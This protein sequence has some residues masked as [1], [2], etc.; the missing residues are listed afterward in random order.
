MTQRG[1]MPRLMPWH[2]GVVNGKDSEVLAA[3]LNVRLHELETL[4]EQMRGSMLYGPIAGA[5]VPFFFS[6]HLAAGI[7]TGI[8]DQHSTPFSFLPLAVSVW[9]ENAASQL[10]VQLRYD[11]G[12]PFDILA[13]DLQFTG[14]SFLNQRA[15]F[16]VD[17]VPAEALVYLEVIS[18]GDGGTA[19]PT[20]IRASL[21]GKEA[22]RIET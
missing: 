11:D 7:P 1:G 21:W 5:Y 2:F 8:Q 17:Q 6:R 4:L 3:D 12:S 9:V 10:T 14:S 20:N 13:V 18:T 15:D 16:A 22:S 19:V